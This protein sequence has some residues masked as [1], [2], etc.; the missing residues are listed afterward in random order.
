MVFVARY[1]AAALL[2]LLSACSL[3]T[4]GIAGSSAGNSETTQPKNSI[5]RGGRHHQ[6]DHQQHI[7]ARQT[8]TIA[9]SIPHGRVVDDDSGGQPENES[10]ENEWETLTFPDERHDEPPERRAL[11]DNVFIRSTNTA[12][13]AGGNIAAGDGDG[14]GAGAGG[15][16]I[17]QH[18]TTA[19][20]TGGVYKHSKGGYPPWPYPPSPTPQ[21]PQW[22]G[23]YP[24]TPTGG[25]GH[26]PHYNPRPTRPR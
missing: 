21:R 2:A 20:R 19:Q 22:P 3:V 17:F 5:L 11:N 13:I 18:D 7:S 25:S 6:G 16:D 24:P 1:P 26:R 8:S 12:T 23:P 15:D 4:F 10:I 9:S 14:G